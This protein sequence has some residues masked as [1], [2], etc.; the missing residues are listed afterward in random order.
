MNIKLWKRKVDIKSFYRDL[1]KG[2][3]LKFDYIE[4]SSGAINWKSIL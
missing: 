3:S 4:G 1:G 2:G